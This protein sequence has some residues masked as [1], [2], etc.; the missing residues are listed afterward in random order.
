MF[1]S[2]GRWFNTYDAADHDVNNRHARQLLIDTAVICQNATPYQ[3][4]IDFADELSVVFKK[5]HDHS[6]QVASHLLRDRRLWQVTAQY[7]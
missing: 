2:A 4:K 1:G 3:H 7:T 5:E 6:L